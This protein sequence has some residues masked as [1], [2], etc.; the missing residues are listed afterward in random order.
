[1]FLRKV[2]IPFCFAVLLVYLLRPI[3]R[4]LSLGRRL[5]CARPK[6]KLKDAEMDV[7]HE[8]SK[9]DLE[10]QN[11]ENV[12]ST[13][14]L[15]IV[16]QIQKYGSTKTV[17]DEEITLGE[18][19]IADAGL[20]SLDPSN[21][22]N[23]KHSYPHEMTL[24]CPLWLAAITSICCVLGFIT[25]LLL[26]VSNDILSFKHNYLS[27]YEKELDSL[28]Q[29]A[30]EW[31]N[32]HF[33]VQT[34]LGQLFVD[35]LKQSMY[36]ASFVRYFLMDTTTI[37]ANMFV[38]CLFV[39]YLLTEKHKDHEE[40]SVFK[41]MN[42]KIQL[43]IGLKTL[44]SVV[45]GICSFVIYSLLGLHLATFFAVSTLLLNFIPNL[46]TFDHANFFC[47]LH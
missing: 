34:E 8:G 21:T 35:G 32:T 40:N 23:E 18:I 31:V 13:K 15:L 38:V 41:K 47:S 43:Y 22:S 27:E 4:F 9:Y 30:T 2:L 20:T 46:V 29:R 37:L 6:R 19:G 45:V 16:H 28:N 5:P 12:L 7:V 17:A 3:V 26:L 33:H 42:T 36:T 14:P 1:M 11:P 39:I 24:R 25:I 44:I 10:G